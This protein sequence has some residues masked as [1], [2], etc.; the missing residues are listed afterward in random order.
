[1]QATPRPAP[2]PAPASTPTPALAPFTA[3]LLPALVMFTLGLWGLDRGTM[4]RDEGTTL[5]VARRS[6]PEI[7][8]LVHR[9]D[10]VHG[11][12][13]VLMHGVLPAHPG[14]V[15]LRL[16]SVVAASAAAAL[17]AVIGTRLARP[18]VGLWAGLLYAVTPLAGHYAQEGRSYALVAAGAALTTLLLLRAVERSGTAADRPAWSAWCAYAAAATG[19]ALLHELA[20]LLL[21]AHAVTLLVARVPRPARRGW[22]VAACATC[23]LLVPLFVA[24][25]GQSAQVAWL[26]APDGAAAE[27]LL[28]AF[29]GPT[30]L[31]LVGQVLLAVVAL[32]PPWSRAGRGTLSLPGLSLPVVALPL[33]V[34]PP[35]VLL[36]V[37]QRWPLYQDRYVLFALAGLPLL[38]AAGAD[39]VVRGV[40]AALRT[41]PGDPPWPAPRPWLSRG[42]TAVAA[43]G[44][45]A[46]GVT[47]WWQ[48]PLHRLD[49]AV[50]HDREN[51]AG[52]A[53]FAAREVRPGEPVLF[54]PLIARRVSLA[55]PDSFRGAR[56]LALA[57]S[58]DSSGTLYGVEVNPAELRRRLAVVDRLW[59][60]TEPPAL[61]QAQ[62]AGR[63]AEGVKLAVLKREFTPHA[64]Y[65]VRGATLRLYVRR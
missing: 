32:R 63:S 56:D 39:R 9:V 7:W 46:V 25:G 3:A 55:Y 65:T 20:A 44:A 28:R 18:R 2:A 10:A 60:L 17:V 6:L 50:G 31:V 38:V 23:V 59:V 13:Y 15:A 22:A 35:A 51:P 27:R 16:P 62:R 48:L 53:A 12:Y 54:L 43:V 11:L 19:T 26:V 61:R 30:R 57:T 24:S 14:E 47:L 37:S 49:R 5:D 64:T 58:P 1:M 21:V 29:A 8:H 4:W 34:V 40:G 52:A 41:R 33:L 45:A 36:A 42:R